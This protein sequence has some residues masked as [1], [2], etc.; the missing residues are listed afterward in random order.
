[1]LCALWLSG[2]QSGEI[3]N[4]QLSTINENSTTDGA[5]EQQQ[6]EAESERLKEVAR[7][8]EEEAQRVKEEEE[9]RKKVFQA[10]EAILYENIKS[11]GLWN[12]ELGQFGPDSSGITYADLID[13]DNNGI[14]ELY[15][16]Y[17]D[18]DRFIESI[19]GYR[20]GKAVQLENNVFEEG[21]RFAND[22]R[23]LVTTDTVT[24]LVSSGS[25]THGGWTDRYPDVISQTDYSDVVYELQGGEFV[26][27]SAQLMHEVYEEEEKSKN[28]YFRMDNDNQTSISK[29]EYEQTEALYA[30]SQRKQIVEDEVGTKSLGEDVSVKLE[31]VLQT[32][33]QLGGDSSTLANAETKLSKTEKL[34]LN[35]FMDNFADLGKFDYEAYTDEDIMFYIYYA[36]F[37]GTLADNLLQVNRNDNEALI[38]Q[39]EW[40]YYPY[41]A[42]EIHALTKTLF[43][44]ELPEKDYS[45][46]TDSFGLKEVL[47][48]DGKFYFLSPN[49]GSSASYSSAQVQHVYD[50]GGGRYY[51]AYTLF[52]YE[53]WDARDLS[54][55][56]TK[57]SD[58][59][60]EAERD[61]MYNSVNLHAILQKTD[62][63]WRML[64]NQGLPSINMEGEGETYE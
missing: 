33:N 16:V 50:L 11:Y 28:Y 29:E 36:I 46:E 63:G 58:E 47:F 40:Y 52:E 55:L 59:W 31:Q 57:A 51:I 56:K 35:A 22:S 39:D 49:Y 34:K 60:T 8:A 10:Y 12:H 45:T 32:W 25:F 27:V 42:Q 26:K 44:I 30:G 64:F 62:S 20:D 61:Y 13:F 21:N 18:G 17:G 4:S 38:L 24:Y 37:N 15:M 19:W 5:I 7:L 23:Y 1:M 43:G 2:C 6:N 48:K 53:D 14:D 41:K 3:N 54:Y 9:Q